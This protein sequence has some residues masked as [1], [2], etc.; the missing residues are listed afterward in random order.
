MRVWAVM[1][2]RCVRWTVGA[3]EPVAK[4]PP[5]TSKYLPSGLRQYHQLFPSSLCSYSQLTDSQ[6]DSIMTGEAE[7]ED[8]VPT[9]K[10]TKTNKK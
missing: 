3:R 5:S 7:L 8:F 1:V 4:N 9:Q 2:W 10:T 6:F